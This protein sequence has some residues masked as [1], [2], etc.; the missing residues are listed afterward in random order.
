[1]AAQ[2]SVRIL[3]GD[4]EETIRTILAGIEADQ[5]ATGMSELN[6]QVLDGKSVGEEAFSNAVY[7]M[8]FIADRRIVVLTNPLSMAGGRDGNRR[9]TE[10]LGSIPETTCLVP[11]IPD[12]FERKDWVALPVKSFLRKWVADHPGYAVIETHARPDL[13]GMRSW[14]TAKTAELGG[15]I[16]P[17][18]VRLLIGMLGND[19][20]EIRQALDKLLLYVDFK[21]P[22]DESDVSELVSANT[23]VNI[24]SMIDELVA[25]NAKSSLSK[26]HQLADEQDIPGLLAMIT[27]QFR[28]LLQ[29]RE[30]L[31]EGGDG[32]RIGKELGQVDFV[33]NKL[34][35]QARAFTMGRLRS[36]Y[37]ELVAI[38]RTVKSSQSDPLIALD[39]FV[40]GIAAA[41][42]R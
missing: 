32:R 10:L 8:P 6:F 2:L 24:F 41:N 35:N 9:F 18:A 34:A 15:E 37:G 21:R 42:R 22:I 12:S 19:T 31:D 16:E 27:R 1:M 26:L 14:I 20:G 33:A 5:R 13:N 29:A 23:S 7:A 28:L 17:G 3:H 39:L 36:L 40:V 30:I 25:G 4:D 38:D 11:V